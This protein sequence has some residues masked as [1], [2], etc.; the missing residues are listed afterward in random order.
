MSDLKHD[1][2]ASQIVYIQ[3]KLPKDK[4][5]EENK[6][7]A[8]VNTLPKVDMDKITALVELRW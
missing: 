3:S 5:A 8:W 1:V 4:T 2:I 6:F 7:L